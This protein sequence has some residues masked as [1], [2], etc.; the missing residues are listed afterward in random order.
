MSRWLRSFAYRTSLSVWIFVAAAGMAILIALL[1]ISVH[2][3]R[4]AASNPAQSLRFE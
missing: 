4:A 3:L 2:C 1:T